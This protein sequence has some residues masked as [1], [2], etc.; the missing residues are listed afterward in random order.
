VIG[1]VRTGHAEPEATP[2]QAGLNQAERGTIEIAG[3]Y[4][5]GLQGLEDFSYAWL[6][7]A[8]TISRA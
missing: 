1:I 2:I 3:R 7:V 4:R 5:D 6:R 8:T